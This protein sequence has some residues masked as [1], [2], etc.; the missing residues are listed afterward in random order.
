MKHRLTVLFVFLWC[1]MLLRYIFA[2]CVSPRAADISVFQQMLAETINGDAEAVCDVL[3][4][5]TDHMTQIVEGAVT[6][7]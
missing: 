6:E 2:H 7:L 3:Q 1:V 5:Y 4:K